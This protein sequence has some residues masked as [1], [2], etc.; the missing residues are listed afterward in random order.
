MEQLKRF[1]AGLPL[2]VVAGGDEAV[3]EHGLGG[4]VAGLSGDAGFGGV[5]ECSARIDA[6][7]AFNYTLAVM[8]DLLS[9]NEDNI[10]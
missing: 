3:H 8:E 4:Q 5:E 9:G 10:Y 1:P 7:I 6:N 2:L